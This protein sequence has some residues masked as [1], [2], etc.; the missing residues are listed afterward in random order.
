MDLSLY[1][2]E[3]QLDK[4]SSRKRKSNRNSYDDDDDEEDEDDDDDDEPLKKKSTKTPLNKKINTPRLST[5]K[6][7]VVDAS[8]SE[9]DEENLMEIKKKTKNQV[10]T[11]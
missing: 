1:K 10:G 4:I 7:P 6:A 5:R 2:D 9:S 8:S 3:S 11:K